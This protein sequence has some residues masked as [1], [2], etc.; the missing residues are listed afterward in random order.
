MVT[1]TGKHIWKPH[2]VFGKQL[3]NN[4]G[5]HIGKTNRKNTYE[6]HTGNRIGTQHRKTTHRENTSETQPIRKHIGNTYRRTLYE[7][8]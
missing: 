1:Y 8:K 4:I 6:T 2:T 3:T 7:S 5:K